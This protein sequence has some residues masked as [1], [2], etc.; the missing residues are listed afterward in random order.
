MTSMKYSKVLEKWLF[1]KFFFC[2]YCS[3]LAKH[4]SK[5]STIA[6]KLQIKICCWC[7]MHGCSC[8]PKVHL[9][10]RYFDHRIRWVGNTAK[11][12]EFQMHEQECPD[13]FLWPLVTKIES[14]TECLIITE[15]KLRAAFGNRNKSHKITDNNNYLC[16]IFLSI[17]PYWTITR[18][19]IEIS[20]GERN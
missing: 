3:F 18:L 2:F 12:T 5:Q 9:N 13:I 16:L 10:F 17:H 4:N 7:C 20:F 1:T 19:E 14:K 15:C 11:M 8:M 6:T